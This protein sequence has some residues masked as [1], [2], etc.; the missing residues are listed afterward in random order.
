MA[1]LNEIHVNEILTT[2]NSEKEQQQLTNNMQHSTWKVD[3]AQLVK[4]LAI[5][6]AHAMQS[7]CHSLSLLHHL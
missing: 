1:I 4:K 7:H 3:N 5:F 6:H 2:Y